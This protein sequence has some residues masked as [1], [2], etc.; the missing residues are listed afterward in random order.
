MIIAADDFKF[1]FLKQLPIQKRQKGNPKSKSGVRY[2]DIIMAF[3]IETTRLKD[4]EQSVMYIWQWQVGKDT[5]VIGRTWEE[6]IRFTNRLK[7]CCDEKEWFVVY[8]H[9]LAY[10]FQFLKGIYPFTS[11]EVFATD[12]RKVLKCSM[13]GCLEFRCSYF[14]SNMSLDV[15]LDK[16]HVEHKK[17]TLDYSKIR[18]P[19]TPLSDEEMAYC[20]NDVQGL[21]EALYTELEHDGDNLYSVPLTST[22]YVRRD[23]KR[24]LR[25]TTLE[26]R[27]AQMPDW[28]VYE[29][30][31][32]AFR[33]GNTHAN[34]W[35]SG[36]ILDN[37]YSIDRS[38]S[39]PEV[40]VNHQFP[41]GHWFEEENCTFEKLCKIIGRWGKAILMRVS[42]SGIKLKDQFDGCPYLS[43]DKCRN[44]REGAFDNGRILQADYLE[45][46]LTDIDYQIV[47]DH[48][49]FDDCCPIKVYYSRYGYLPPSFIEEVINYYR[50]KTELK[51]NDDADIM[52]TKS[53]NRLNSLYGMCAQNPVKQSIIFDINS[54]EQFYVDESEDL[55]ALLLKSNSKAY[56]NY[57]WGVW[58]TAWARYELQQGIDLAGPEF[59]YCDTDSVKATKILDVSKY[60]AEKEQLAEVNGGFAY[61]SKG[62]KH[63]MGVWEVDGI[64]KRFSTLGAKKYVYIDTDDKLHITIAGVDKKKGAAELMEHGGIE[65]F[66]EGFVFRKGGG[67]EIVYNDNPQLPDL[68]IDGHKL[69]I[70]SNAVIRESTYTL[71]LTEEYRRII[72]SCERLK[73][74]KIKLKY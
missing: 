3:D 21:V 62:E 33:G 38:S 34:R 70:T 20:V 40:L 47:I 45:T 74:F 68:E 51:G 35:Y 37:V 36:E 22:G 7:E 9:N 52:Y 2:K 10:E 12:N 1:D 30:L 15:F 72:E 24:A 39:Y 60:N 59:V 5:T 67:T 64:Y 19:W 8:V 54:P 27:Q 11:E 49:K 41:V 26:Y 14:H 63:C 29:L 66:R 71:G 18:Y 61:D 42:F 48:Y 65:A 44:I 28:D 32:E 53:K 57:A 56:L 43:R 6:F 46:T 55:K 50:L 31:Y 25:H 16:M 4:I 17:L 69:H 58:C 13:L 73:Y 23:A